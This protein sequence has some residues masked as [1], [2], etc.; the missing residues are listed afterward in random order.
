MKE[1]KH[2]VQY[3][4][5]DKMGI[6]HHSNYIRWMEESRV[7]FLDQIG[8]S[9]SKFEEMGIISPVASVECAFKKPT[10]F[11]DTVTIVVNIAEYNGVKIVF[12]Y[13]MKNDNGEVVAEGKSSH[14]FIDSKKMPMLVKK[15]LPELH[16]TLMSLVIA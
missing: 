3:Y 12:K 5:T 15:S 2:T 1:Y 6:S 7:D 11:P 14:C 9:Y 10:T 16:E 13:T 4:E 8:W